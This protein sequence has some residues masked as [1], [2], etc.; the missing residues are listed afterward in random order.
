M[1]KI[2][3]QT[4][5]NGPGRQPRRFWTQHSVENSSVKGSS[6]EHVRALFAELLSAVQPGVVCSLAVV[7][8]SVHWP[9]AA[10]HRSER[11]NFRA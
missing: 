9:L 2:L 10:A 1:Q 6:E 4:S 8:H 7:H 5:R 3:G 11:L